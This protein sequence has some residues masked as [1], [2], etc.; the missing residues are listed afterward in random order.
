[1]VN[2]CFCDRCG[3]ELDYFA[4]YEFSVK[5]EIIIEGN[6]DLCRKCYLAFQSFLKSK[7]KSP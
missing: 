2:K 1:M 5:K 4:R 7:E 6:Y 3:E